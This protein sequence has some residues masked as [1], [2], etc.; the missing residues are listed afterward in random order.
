MEMKNVFIVIP[1]GIL[2]LLNLSQKASLFN[3]FYTAGQPKSWLSY[4]GQLCAQVYGLSPLSLHKTLLSRNKRIFFTH[5][6]CSVVHCA[7]EL[8]QAR[9]NSSSLAQTD[10]KTSVSTRNILFPGC[11]GRIFLDQKWVISFWP[12]NIRDNIIISPSRFHAQIMS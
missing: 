9:C 7:P 11:M 2:Y 10:R 3:L 8:S 12:G 5:F 4:H 6:F 1:I